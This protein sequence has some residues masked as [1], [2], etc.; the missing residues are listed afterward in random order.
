MGLDA[1]LLTRSLAEGIT[2]A[3]N[4]YSPFA[5]ATAL[6]LTRWIKSVDSLR[7]AL[8]TRGWTRLDPQ[9]APRSV[10]EDRTMA[11]ALMSGDA[12]TAQTTG[13]PTTVRPS[14]PVLQAEVE[15]NAARHSSALPFQARFDL[16]ESAPLA[17]AERASEP[18][19]WVLL[20]FWDEVH[21][22]LL[23]ELSLPISIQDGRITRWATRIILPTTSLAPEL[24][25]SLDG[26]PSES[27]DFPIEAVS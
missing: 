3:M 27:I 9:N 11:I 23:A 13:S 12:W 7:R 4:D 19:T 22:E 18:Q 2:A 16:G 6:G 8:D 20:S 14:G 21:R 15:R 26:I 10:S 17:N 5:P 1:A 24:A 25:K